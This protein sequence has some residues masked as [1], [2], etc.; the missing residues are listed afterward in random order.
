MLPIPGASKVSSITD[1]ARAADLILPPEDL[2]RVDEM[3]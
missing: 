1:S 3:R 2:Q